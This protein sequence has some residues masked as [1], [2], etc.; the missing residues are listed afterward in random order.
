MAVAD[1]FYTGVES[2]LEAAH[3]RV[4]T[5]ER[6]L[7]EVI[8]RCEDSELWSRNGCRGLPEWLSQRLGVSNWKARRMVAAAEAL[9]SLPR[10]AQALTE[11]RLSLDKVVELTRFAT[12][13]TEKKL[14]T[15]ARRGIP[16]GDPAQG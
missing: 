14:I 13:E 4:T 3:A 1:S 5:S 2:E 9:P 7:L 15:W 16:R 6:A 10:M 11:G 12:P 8:A